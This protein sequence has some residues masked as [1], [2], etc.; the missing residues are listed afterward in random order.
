MPRRP[1]PHPTRTALAALLAATLAA[2]GVA[3][4]VE[5][6][7][8]TAGES[9]AGLADGA[10]GSARA[11]ASA[12]SEARPVAGGPREGGGSAEPAGGGPGPVVAP[13]PAPEPP[14]PPPLRDEAIA[15]ALADLV[16]QSHRV[17]RG[18]AQLGLDVRAGAAQSA[19]AEAL[20]TGDRRIAVLAAGGGRRITAARQRE[21]AIRWRALREA[22]ATRPAPPIAALMADVAGQ[23]AGVAESTAGLPAPARAVRQRILLERMVG[24]HLLG[25]WGAGAVP[26]ARRLAWRVEFGR[27]LDDALE[28]PAAGRELDAATAR[29]QWGLLALGLDATG[30]PCDG[31]ALAQLVGTGERLAGLLDAPPPRLSAARRP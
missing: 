17:V 14:R 1:V 20:R 30:S 19:L 4:A 22:A 25:C 13:E 29:S 5:A 3:G 11:A 15:A 26:T 2:G 18:Y 27:L 6:V 8:P 21:L 16:E 31:S 10:D 28:A 9:H 7:A 12:S 23:L 24:A